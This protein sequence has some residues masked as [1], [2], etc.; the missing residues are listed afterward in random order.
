MEYSVMLNI[1]IIK[2]HILTPKS[3]ALWAMCQFW[4]YKIVY[5]LGF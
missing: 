3:V 2:L 5:Y 1:I 4:I